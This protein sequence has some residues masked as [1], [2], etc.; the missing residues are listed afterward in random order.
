MAK[1]KVNVRKDYS[2]ETKK[3]PPKYAPSRTPRKPFYLIL[4]G[5]GMNPT[6]V[7][8]EN[9]EIK[10][11]AKKDRLKLKFLAAKTLDDAIKILKEALPWATGA[12]FNQGDLVDDETGK[13]KRTISKLLYPTVMI[14]SDGS[15]EDALE[16][17]KAKINAS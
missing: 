8:E 1:K 11:F 16:K 15:Y 17:L 13:L 4:R 10:T 5:P 12:V 2:Y 6:Q 14:Q 7:I 9:E 3:S